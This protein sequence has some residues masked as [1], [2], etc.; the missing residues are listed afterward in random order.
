MDTVPTAGPSLAW[1]AGTVIQVDGAEATSKALGA[2][3]GEAV[4]A[5][6]AGGAVST[7]PHQTVVYVHLAVG[8]HK[9]CQAAAREVE[10]K[11]L[12]IL[13]LPAILAWG[14]GVEV[15]EGFDTDSHLHGS[16]GQHADHR[17]LT[18]FQQCHA[19]SHSEPPM[20]PLKNGNTSSTQLPH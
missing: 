2:E 12:V 1:T 8:T 17:H 3:A 4:Y 9:A 19:K 16:P 6:H 5:V 10:G 14:A 20:P 13:A 18:P 11:A 7:R 15:G